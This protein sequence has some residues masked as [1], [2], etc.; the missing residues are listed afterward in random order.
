MERP[1]WADSALAY[2]GDVFVYIFLS[3]FSMRRLSAA[4][5]IWCARNSWRPDCYITIW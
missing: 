4:R 2:A 1:A 5:S 3:T